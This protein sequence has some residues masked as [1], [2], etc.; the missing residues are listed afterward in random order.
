MKS[1]WGGKWFWNSVNSWMCCKH[2]FKHLV[3][4]CV[5]CNAHIHFGW[6]NLFS[7]FMAKFTHHTLFN[8]LK[9]NW[10]C[11]RLSQP[12]VSYLNRQTDLVSFSFTTRLN[13]VNLGF[14]SNPWLIIPNWVNLNTPLSL[15]ECAWGEGRM[16]VW[17]PML[18]LEN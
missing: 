9:F 17:V 1:N 11:M 8:K 2:N 3:L 6:F 18:V 12:F 4:V 7:I 10:N 14:M 16:N 15:C 13:A 5:Q